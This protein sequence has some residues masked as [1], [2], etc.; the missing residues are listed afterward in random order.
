MGAISKVLAR[1]ARFCYGRTRVEVWL[2]G[3]YSTGEWDMW[4]A[5]VNY[6]AP[7]LLPVGVCVSSLGVRQ[8]RKMGPASSF[9]PLVPRVV[10]PNDPC[11]FSTHSEIS[12]Q[13]LLPKT[14]ASL[15]Y[16]CRVMCCTVSLRARL[17]FL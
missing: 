6:V 13:I 10:S 12:K 2:E 1:F 14:A 11:P 8:K 16:L 4:C 15:L 17:S 5:V 7:T 3:A 9:V